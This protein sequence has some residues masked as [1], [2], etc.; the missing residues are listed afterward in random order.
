MSTN[1]V[2]LDALIPR[3]DFKVEAQPQ[4]GRTLDTISIIHLEAPFF[5]PDLRKPDFQRETAHWSPQKVVDLLRAFVDADLIPAVILWRSGRFLFVVDGAHRLSA[6]LAWVQDD[7]GDRKKSLEFFG[8]HITEEQRKIAE[9]TRSLVA[10][11]IGSYQ[12]YKAARSDPSGAS[13]Q[14]KKRLSNLSVVNIIAQWVPTTDAASAEA[15][16]FKINQ[17]ATPVEQTERRILQSRR[18]ASAIAA[19]A[20]THAGTGHKY[21]S[22]FSDGTKTVIEQAGNAIY[23]ALYDPPVGSTV[24]TLDVPVAGRGYSALPFVFEFVNEA[25]GVTFLA[26]TRR[27]APKDRLPGDLDGSLTVAYLQA[28]EKRLN[29]LTGDLPM[30]LGVHP[31]VY[32]YTRSGTFQPVALMATSRFLENL[33]AKDKLRHFTRVRAKFEDFLIDHKEVSSLLIHKYGAGP[34]SLPGFTAYY[35]RV[36]AE[37]LAN[38]NPEAV[39]A[40]LAADSDF[41]FL[42]APRP[43]GIRDAPSTAKRTFSSSTKTAAYFA[44][45]LPGCVRCQICGARVHKNSMNIDHIQ[46][47]RDGGSADMSNAQVTHPYCNSTKG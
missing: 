13:D 43:S 28:V 1:V 34:R 46:P 26:N 20:I 10:K 9:R 40:S 18:S 44:A 8:G 37:F 45:A 6:L 24:T 5:G 47:A 27:K 33:A 12:E 16:F 39:Q 31:V 4:T 3:E 25:N 36:L 7:Y 14:L 38:K 32:F 19:R 2:N 41:A 42:T 22:E 11:E 21:W 23:K 30:S 35:E 17:A 15:S 29:R